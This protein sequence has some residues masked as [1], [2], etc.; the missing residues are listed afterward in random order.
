[1]KEQVTIFV[2]K[3][4]FGLLFQTWTNFSKNIFS[5]DF[6]SCFEWKYCAVSQNVIFISC[7]YQHFSNCK[8]LTF[9][10]IDWFRFQKPLA[11]GP[12]WIPR[13]QD[14]WD[15]SLGWF[16]EYWYIGN[17]RKDGN[18]YYLHS[19]LTIQLVYTTINMKGEKKM[20]K[21]L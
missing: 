20:K 16:L 2:W 1:M 3:K 14:F 12:F 21:K 5:T 4:N 13:Y 9:C 7:I 6:I 17:S 18:N 19:A 8:F 10:S 15:K 11:I